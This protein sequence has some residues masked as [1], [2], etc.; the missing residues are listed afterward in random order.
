MLL[1][2]LFPHG[3]SRAQGAADGTSGQVGGPF[4]HPVS[5]PADA[6]DHLKRVL[7][8]SGSES[9]VPSDKELRAYEN[10]VTPFHFLV[11]RGSVGPVRRLLA[12]EV[13]VDGQT[14]CGS[15]AL[16]IATQD[17]QPDLCGLLL[18]HGA[19]ANLA[20]E[21]G[22]AALH[23]AAQHGTATLPACS[24]TTGPARMPGSTRAGPPSTWPHRTTL[25]TWHG[26]WSPAR[27][28]STCRRPRARPLSTWPPTSAT[29][30]RSSC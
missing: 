8:L 17:R 18:E 23:F 7:Q 25:R 16:L 29:S 21:D 13:D 15:T 11:A 2:A 19:D 1:E 22:W 14:A 3:A 5:V 28:T 27:L 24:W 6:G 20:D 10:K 9:L 30:A 26:S 4:S 12:H